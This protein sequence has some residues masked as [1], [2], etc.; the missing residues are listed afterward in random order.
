MRI[1]FDAKRIFFNQSGLGNYGRNILAALY[2]FYPANDYFLFTPPAS[3]ALFP[4]G[5][6][7]MV[8]P[9]GLY[10]FFSAYWRNNR[11]GREARHCRTDIYHGLSNELPR[12]IESAKTKSVVSIHDTIFMRYPQWY[13]WHDRITY[14][15]KTAFA[16][17]KA[18]VIVAVSEQ[19]KND[20]IH[21]FKVKEEKIQVI[22]Q[23]CSAVFSLET[24]EEQHRSVREKY[25]LPDEFILMVGNIEKRKNILNVINAMQDPRIELPL[26]VVGKANTYAEELKQYIRQRD[27]KNVYFCHTVCSLDLPIV[28][29][30]AKVFVYPSFFEGFGIPIIEAMSSG[31]PIIASNTAALQ[32]VAADAALYVA[33]DNAGEIGDT[34]YTMLSNTCLRN[35]LT[36]KGEKQVKRF[37]AENIAREVINLY[38]SL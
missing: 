18:D 24:N 37:Q 3:A 7:D 15:H 32:E 26:V 12:D 2:A 31:V 35:S 8:T 28:Y 30:L 4:E 6:P 38:K 17:Q 19:T 11:I 10:R 25:A 36:E 20:L 29:R 27:I 5:K 16:C 23:P 22:H 14:T 34:I 9:H 13:K 1:G 33:A 21:F